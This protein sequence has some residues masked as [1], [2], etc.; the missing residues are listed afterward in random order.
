M[1][2]GELSVSE[3]GGTILVAIVRTGDLSQPATVTFGVTPNDA[4]EGEDYLDATGSITFEAGQ[5]RVLVPISILD[6]TLGEATESFTLSLISTDSGV[7]LAPRT[8]KIDILDN[9]IPATDPP[10]QGLISTFDLQETT[11][12]GDLDLPIAVQF[13]PTDPNIAYVAEK[14][15]IIKMVDMTTGESSVFLDISSQV[16]NNSDRGLLNFVLHPEFE[17]NGLFYL[18]YVVD[19]SDVPFEDGPANRFAYVSRFEA[20]ASTGFTTVIEDSEV[21]LVGGSA[22]SIDDIN[23]GGGRERS[24]RLENI[25]VPPSDY[26]P[27]TGEAVQDYIKVDST[28]HAGGGMAFGPDGALY[29]ATGDGIA[30]NFTDPRGVS[31]QDVNT[32]TGK[33]LRI[34]PITGDGFADNPFATSDLSE[35]AS[36]VYQLGLRNPFRL[37]FDQNGNLLISETGWNAYEE[38]N[39]GPPGANYGWPFYEGGDNGII[40]ETDGYKDLPEAA[41]FYDA[42]AAGD[43][44]I[45]SAFRAFSHDSNA[46]GFQVQAITGSSTVYSGGRYEGNFD[47]H[48]FFADFSGNEIYAV[49]TNDRRDITYLGSVDGFRGP[50]DFV[51]DANGFLYYVDIVGGRVVRIDDIVETGGAT[52]VATPARELLQG[53]AGDDT[54]VFAPGTSTTTFTDTIVAWLPGDIID[55]TALNITA[56]DLDVRLISDGATMKIA[57]GFGPDDFQLKIKLNSF[58][59]EQVLASIVYDAGEFPNGDTT[60]PPVASDDSVLTQSETEVTFNVLDNDFDTDGDAFSIVS[61]TQPSN[62]VLTDL[63]DGNFSYVPSAAFIGSDSFTYTI[64]DANG[65]QNSASVTVQV[66]SNDPDAANQIFAT[67]GQ[68]ENLIGTVGL[69]NF[70]FAPG[71]STT[72]QTDSIVDM[73]LGDVIDLSALGLTEADLQFR[74][75]GDG[76]ILKIIQGFGDDDFQVKVSLSNITEEQVRAA[77]RYSNEPD[78]TPNTPPV[79]NQDDTSTTVATAV[80]INVVANDMDA[81]NDLLSIDSFTQGINGSV[82]DLGNG[83]LE[84]TPNA[85]FVGDDSFT[86]TISDPDGD[87]STATVNVSVTAPVNAGP[88]AGDDEAGTDINTPVSINV[89]TNDTDPEDDALTVDSFTQGA[90]GSV[91][92][93]G[94]GVLQYTPNADFVGDDSFTYTISDPDGETS[95]ATVDVTV[96]PAPPENTPPT[97]NDDDASTDSDTAVSINVLANDSDPENDP[98]TVVDVSDGVNGTVSDLG[99]G[100]LQYTPNQGFVGEDVF[101]Y[102]VSDPDGATSVASVAVSV[103]RPNTPPIAIEDEIDTNE[104][105]AAT[106]NV[107]ANDSDPDGDNFSV[108]AFTQGMNGSVVNLGDGVFEYTPNAGFI[109]FDSFSYQ[110]QDEFGD[111]SLASVMIT[112][113]PIATIVGTIG[114]DTL[115]GTESRDVIDGLRGQDTIN[116]NGGDDLAFGKDGDDTINGGIGN[117]DLVGGLGNDTL[118]GNEND[119]RLFGED[120]NDIL[121]GGAGSDQLFGQA[122]DDI[123]NGGPG[124]D[125]LYPDTGADT[126]VIEPDSGFDV[127]SGFFIVGED[128]IDVRA[129]NLTSAE[130]LA[131]VTQENGQTIVNFGDGNQLIL[132]NI[133]ESSLSE[134]NFIGVAPPPEPDFNI[135]SASVGRET[136]SGT[137]AADAYTFA[138]GT[139]VNGAIDTIRDWAPGDIIDLSALGLTEGDFQARTANNGTVLK[140]IEGFG[141]GEFH[142]R[143]NLNGYSQEEVLNS[144]VYDSGSLPP[145]PP[146]P[147]PTAPDAVDDNA[148]AI[149]DTAISVDVLA[150]DTD[151][152]GDDLTVTSFG[153]GTNGTVTDLG[154]GNLQYS[155]NPGF[156]GQDTFTY[157]VSDGDLSSD[158]SVTVNVTD[159]SAVNVIA[160]SVGRESLSGTDGIDAFTFAPGTSVNGAI[161]TI[162]DWAPGDIIDLS[163]LGLTEGNI[164]LRTASNGTV[165][166]LIEGFGDGEFHVRIN[167]NGYSQEEVL[168]SIVYASTTEV[169]ASSISAEKASI[170]E[171]YQ[172]IKD[173]SEFETEKEVD[174]AVHMPVKEFNP[175]PDGIEQMVADLFEPAA[176]RPTQDAWLIEGMDADGG[177]SITA[178]RTNIPGGDNLIKITDEDDLPITPTPDWDIS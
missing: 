8:A 155:P 164:Q 2:S 32:L 41:A 96:A 149:I 88:T 168:D 107:L 31:V 178:L 93:L 53:S 130:A 117:D 123:L 147:P 85:D 37:T 43:I 72:S 51:Q 159:P 163:A 158:A 126:I 125:V 106:V 73:A 122:G 79:A 5:S 124:N 112:V 111:T 66:I 137:E 40:I 145:P 1:E 6:D 45:S 56:D 87:T 71:T 97:A 12:A 82:A 165:L 22:T 15:G 21:V 109:G 143:I 142:V 129:L 172:P 136:L 144:V 24:D 170:F 105:T 103:L 11:V 127:V 150:N 36:K 90:N 60:R 101:L 19:P 23:G 177:S 119:D 89:L 26:D 29:I 114:D 115:E 173:T 118:N 153:Q 131:L 46:P 10:E 14:G 113:R 156:I 146:P 4:T 140:L 69:D 104:G 120:D 52:I 134:S 169:A 121:N 84:Y 20:D 148:E 61:F 57:L 141:S 54:Y 3:T 174:S 48:Y 50:V 135:V 161:D 108:N 68:I 55:L 62:G 78:D 25:D 151:V 76:T 63:G 18:Y 9:E 70:V 116:A 86:Y 176:M 171:P 16:N 75:V 133:D 65:E 83:V 166:K 49:N 28:S 64:E 95:S 100:V 162:R 81:D 58:T 92:D 157:T 139:S 98:L 59:T 91:A 39:S 17:D 42:V 34:D 94:N 132:L 175:E 7:L 44:V 80:A 154:N 160:A 102:A 128:K 38:I 110:V 138:P 167:L 30:F 47:N 99:N 13:S 67:A 77:I 74:V 27:V 35:N 152:N 33:V